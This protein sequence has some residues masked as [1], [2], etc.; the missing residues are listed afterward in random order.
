MFPAL[1]WSLACLV[2]GAGLGFLF[3]VPKVV[4]EQHTAGK[5][6]Q[7]ATDA[8]NPQSSGFVYQQRVNSNLEEISDWLTKIIVGLGL[9]ELAKVFDYFKRAATCIGASVGQAD[10]AGQAFGASVISFS[11]A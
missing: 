9:V 11:A 7:V 8:N 1:L 2:S 3:G 10:F 5:K 4:Q 6:D